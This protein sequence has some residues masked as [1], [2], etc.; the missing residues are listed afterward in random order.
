MLYNE[1]LDP[2]P[3]SE[4]AS[5][6]VTLTVLSITYAAAETLVGAPRISHYMRTRR[7][8]LKSGRHFHYDSV[9]ARPGCGAF[10]LFAA[11][12]ITALNI[13]T[14]PL[15]A[16]HWPPLSQVAVCSMTSSACH[17]ASRTSSLQSTSA[18]YSLGSRLWLHDRKAYRQR[19]AKYR[20]EDHTQSANLFNHSASCVSVFKIQFRWRVVR[21]QTA[22]WTSETNGSSV[23]PRNSAGSIS[24]GFCSGRR[25]PFSERSRCPR[26][27][28]RQAN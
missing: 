18:A 23:R 9:T 8:C 10:A 1:Q 16:G 3:A 19:V 21:H 24:N 20:R 22:T 25:D 17:C 4:A 7:S 26:G 13:A 27:T 14:R 15:S 11:T 6:V 28:K 2:V 12:I 5:I